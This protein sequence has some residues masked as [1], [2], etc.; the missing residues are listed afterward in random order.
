MV[1]CWVKNIQHR[2]KLLWCL[3]VPFADKRIC[4]ETWVKRMFRIIPVKANEPFFL[5]HEGSDRFPLTSAQVGYLL[6]KWVKAV[7]IDETKFT[8]N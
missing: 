1:I 3:L 2:N 4:S 5:I 6:K 8:P 7:D